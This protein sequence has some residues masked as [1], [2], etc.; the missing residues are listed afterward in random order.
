MTQSDRDG[1][2]KGAWRGDGTKTEGG[3]MWRVAGKIQS[4]IDY[5]AR[6]A[7]ELD[8]HEPPRSSPYM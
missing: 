8:H 4:E 7:V 1:G 6:N 2:G 5:H 3:A